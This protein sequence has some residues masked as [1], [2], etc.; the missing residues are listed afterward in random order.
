MITN[1]LL[2]HCSLFQSI[3]SVRPGVAYMCQSPRSSK[4]QVLAWHWTS[5]LHA[6]L[7]YCQ[8]DHKKQNQNTN[9]SF[10]ENVFE[11]VL[12]KI[13]NTL[14]MPLCLNDIN[15][16]EQGGH[17]RINTPHTRMT[18]YHFVG[19]LRIGNQN[20]ELLAGCYVRQISFCHTGYHHAR[21]DWYTVKSL[22]LNSSRIVS[23][24]SLPNPLK[25]GVK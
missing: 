13:W 19:Q 9:G 7:T 3:N 23:Q 15:S 1:D 17:I 2:N 22:N 11:D 25:P 14:F 16:T 12:G 24:V 18:S 6:K 21:H 4:V 20:R 5:S 8:L 10:W